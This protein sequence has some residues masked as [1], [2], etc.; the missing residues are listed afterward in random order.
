M[1]GVENLYDANDLLR[2]MKQAA[3][4]ANE[5]SKPTDILYGTV[6]SDSPL[7]IQLEQKITLTEKQLILTRN[8][9]DYEIK[10]SLK[11]DYGWI[12]EDTQQGTKIE[13]LGLGKNHK[14]DIKQT[15]KKIF[16]H[17]AL[18]KDEKVILIRQRGGQKYLVLD[19]TVEK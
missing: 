6:I 5:Q 1:L 12:T 18:K 8:V 11:S 10:V 3:K 14:H 9:T 15:E 16:I 2:A 19:R 7:K 13:S 4:D 17:N